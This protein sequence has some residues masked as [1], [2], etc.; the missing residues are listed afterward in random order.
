MPRL[1]LSSGVQIHF[2]EE[3]PQA[4]SAVLLLHGLGATSSSWQGHIS[5][6]AGAGFRVLAP[7][8]RGFGESSYPGHTGIGVLARDMAELLENLGAAP[9]H[10]VG[11]S[12]GGTV[13]Q[14]L[15]LDYTACVRSLVLVNTFARLRP[16]GPRAWVYFLMR[17]ALVHTLGLGTQA[18]LVGRH[19]FPRPDQAELRR[20]LYEQVV[21]AN[22]RAYRATM[23]ALWH[24]D[25]EE[26]LSD[27]RVPVLVVTGAED[28]TV[29]P[30]NQQVLTDR[31]PGARHV[32]V[33]G[34][35]H[36]V[37]ADQPEVFRRVV[38]EFLKA[39]TTP[40]SD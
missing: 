1:V 25:V 22:P 13:A 29:S 8:M 5:W 40:P 27:I 2:L 11:I 39:E 4:S 19:M 17:F 23:R 3:N 6:L 14:Q 34:A 12:L 18:R 36:A 16:E 28:S 26:R 10:V 38:G 21:N 33:A 37:P 24:F 31:I 30:R 35:N 9:A 20:Q 15:A 7:D 32:A